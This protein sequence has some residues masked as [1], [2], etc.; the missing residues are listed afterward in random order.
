MLLA[1]LFAL[2]PNCSNLALAHMQEPVRSAIQQLCKLAGI[3]LSNRMTRNKTT[4]LICRADGAASEKCEHAH[5][6]GSVRLVTAD[7][8]FESVRRGE[9]QAEDAFATPERRLQQ[10]VP[11]PAW[12]QDDD[13]RTGPAAP[14]NA[15]VD[16]RDGLHV[17]HAAARKA[18][19]ASKLQMNEP[20]DV[21][22]VVA[23]LTSAVKQ[24][25]KRC[26][27]CILL[28]HARFAVSLCFNFTPLLLQGAH[29]WSLS[30]IQA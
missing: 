13:A 22:D 29:F 7:W 28:P 18:A 19:Q 11:A 6:W 15:A 30:W 23:R 10:L 8:V 24:T 14:T 27:A 26:A 4:H 9:R 17:A 20:E 2:C 25:G 3:K 5:A 1:A 12:K 21:L 16:S